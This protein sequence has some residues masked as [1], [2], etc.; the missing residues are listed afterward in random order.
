MDI[1]R[2]QHNHHTDRYGLLKPSDPRFALV[3]PMNGV[4][5]LMEGRDVELRRDME[6]GRLVIFAYNEGGCNATAVDLLD[7]LTWFKDDWD[8]GT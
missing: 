6:T 7:I 5:E 8:S 2:T 3:A 4:G 1:E